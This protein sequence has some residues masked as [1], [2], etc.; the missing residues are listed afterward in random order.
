M[1]QKIKKRHFVSGWTLLLMIVCSGFSTLGIAAQDRI[2]GTVSDTDGTPLPGVNVIQKGTSQ[3]AVTDFDGKYSITLVSGNRTLEFSYVG[4]VT[5]EVRIV[6]QTTVNVNL[7]ADTESLEEVVVIGY[8]AIAKE[9]VLGAISSVDAEEIE[10]ATPTSAF[11]A[12]QGKLAGVQILSNN[13]PGAGFDIQIRGVS[14][15]GA[16]TSPLYVVDGQQLE[17]IDNIDPSTIKSLEV[18]KDGATASIYGSRAANGVVLITTKSGK[19]G[20]LTV[21]VT[22]NVGYN[23]LVGDVPVANSNERLAYVRARTNNFDPERLTGEERDSLSLLVRNSFDLQELVTRTAERRQ[24]NVAIRGGGEK[25]RFY[26]NTGYLEEQGIVIG[27]KYKRLSTLLSLDTDFGKKLKLGSKINLTF[28]DRDGLAEANVLRQLV[29]RI[30]NFPVFE[31]NGTLTPTIA[32]RQNPIAQAL[33]RTANDRNWRTQVFNYADWTFLPN[34]SVRSTLGIN[35]RYRKRDDFEPVLVQGNLNRPPTGR[36]RNNLSY[37]IQ[38]ENVFSY[39]NQWGDHDLDVIAGMQIQKWFEEGFDVRGNF[40]SDDISTFNNVDPLV[41]GVQTNGTNDQRHNLFSLFGR[42]RYDYNSKYLVSASLRRDGSSRFGDNNEYGYFPS[43]SAGWRLSKEDFLQDSNVINNLLLRASYGVIGN[44]NIPNYA[45]TSALVPGSNYTSSGV[46]QSRLGNPDLSWESTVST[47]IGFNLQ[48]F[49]RRIDFDVD[50][51]SKETEDLLANVPLPEESGFSQIL[52]NVGSV[53]NRGID[54]SLGIDLIRGKD[55]NWDTN[56][57]ISIFENEVKQLAGG[58]PFF[59]SG[60]YFIEEGQPIG[61]IFGYV[62]G[63]IFQYTESNAFTDD[64]TQLTPN[65]YEAGEFVNYTLNGDVFTGNINQL[66]SNGRTLEG[67]DIIWED[68]NGDFTIDAANDR[69]VIGNGLPSAFG[70]W[71]NNLEYKNFKLSFLFDYSLGA[72]IYKRWDEER[73]DLNSSNETPS[74][75]F[76]NNA[77]T[78]EGDVTIWPRLN[79]VPQLRNDPSS[80]FIENGDWVKLRYVRLNYN[81]PRAFLDRFNWLGALSVNLAVNN[82]LTWTEYTG[83]NP[84]LGRRGNALTPNFDTLRYPND[85][86]FIVGLRVQLK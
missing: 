74:P 13:G 60:R 52:Q 81:V 83:Y 15:F 46:S 20:T 56:F 38:Q 58:T 64:G 14:T 7:E 76:I 82:V 66:R 36:F 26:W 61:N 12:V 48:M 77:W 53:E 30:P 50:F 28:E 18:L 23:N 24:T 80:F 33:V 49:D 71:F 31:P 70:G 5:K 51:W 10:Q 39:S 65:F 62:N 25:G 17:N 63:G 3:G 67:G 55:F 2:T 19:S 44:E 72:D 22:A 59:A 78:Q 16:G 32:G 45:F 86:E 43:L 8:G 68:L 73:N 54:F 34:V 40:I 35:M 6:N 57:N 29:A 27:S 47:N 21:D 9:K 75:E 11:D 37:D 69:K 1:R 85:R 84:E 41:F 4:F 42:M 79:R